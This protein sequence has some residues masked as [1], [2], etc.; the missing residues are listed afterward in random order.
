MSN[1][2]T[3]LEALEGFII[4]KAPKHH[5]SAKAPDNYAQLREWAD[6]HI[7]GIDSMPVSDAFSDRTIYRA[8][9]VNYAFR[10]W[11]DALHLHYGLNTSTYDELE[12]A[13][14]HKRALAGEVGCFTAEAQ[15]ILW[16]D[17]AGQ[18][19]YHK[20]HGRFPANQRGFVLAHLKNWRDAM[21]GEWL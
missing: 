21:E 3:A 15:R 17:T 11:H 8:P 10:A 1:P 20:R 18:T 9:A 4:A 14:K 5:T 19:F 6:T 7:V 2:K 13:A 12:V 16:A